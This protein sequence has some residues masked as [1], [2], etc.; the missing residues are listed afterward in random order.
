MTI[1]FASVIPEQIFVKGASMCRYMYPGSHIQ[2]VTLWLCYRSPADE[3]LGVTKKRRKIVTNKSGSTIQLVFFIL[4][5]KKYFSF[6]VLQWI[7]YWTDIS[8]FALHICLSDSS[9]PGKSTWLFHIHTM[10]I[11]NS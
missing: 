3:D 2:C 10:N 4:F 1:Y 5:K 7:N 9:G 11:S 6:H 8:F